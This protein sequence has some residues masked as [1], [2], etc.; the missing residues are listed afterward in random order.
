MEIF[1]Q[2]FFISILGSDAN[3]AHAAGG[4]MGII[5]KSYTLLVIRQPWSAGVLVFSSVPSPFSPTPCPLPPAPY[6]FP[7][8]II[9]LSGKDRSFSIVQGPTK[10]TTPSMQKAQPQFGR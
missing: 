5:V 3:E 4:H 2:L 9:R 1:L 7:P 8:A 6:F 10:A